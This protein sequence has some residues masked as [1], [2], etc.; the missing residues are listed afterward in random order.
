MAE[1]NSMS[2]ARLLGAGL[3]GAGAGVS[4]LL[5]RWHGPRMLAEMSSR[6]APLYRLPTAH[7][8]LTFRCSSAEAVK[9]AAR[10]VYDEPE[11]IW[12]IDNVVR[13]G[14]C[15]WD[16][17]ANV[18]LYALYAALRVGGEGRV[19]AFE[20]AADNYAALSRNVALNKLDHVVQGFCA[21]L[22]DETRAA[23]LHLTSLDAGRAAHVFGAVADAF[24]DEARPHVQWALGY[25]PDAFIET[26][27]V[28]AP[29]HLKI[30]VDSIEEKIVRGGKAAFAGTRSMIVELNVGDAHVAHKDR[31]RQ[32]IAE[33]G[34]IEHEETSTRFPERRNRI[35]LRP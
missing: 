21:A 7:G 32:A 15:V 24:S 1:R 26:F 11:T 33:L 14:D 25:S 23:Q 9:A 31:L 6:A 2:V 3:A 35:F 20:P 28:R 18:G 16:I 12:W 13:P 22:S 5:G 30:D 27:K 8:D 19:V 17:G 29:D 34:F 10:F 4:R